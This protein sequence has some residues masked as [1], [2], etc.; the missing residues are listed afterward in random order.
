MHIPKVRERSS[1][2]IKL[3]QAKCWIL[4]KGKVEKRKWYLSR[5]RVR[6][7][8]YAEADIVIEVCGKNRIQADGKTIERT[9]K[10]RKPFFSLMGYM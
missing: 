8:G 3:C 10:H 2:R 7:D 6:R 1:S 9:R 5:C 4:D